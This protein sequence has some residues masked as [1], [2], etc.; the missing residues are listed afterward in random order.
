MSSW[1]FKN[2][3]R[4]IATAACVMASATAM[5]QD[6]KLTI[7]L[8][9]FSIGQGLSFIAQE[10]GFFKRERLDV[11]LLDARSGA[12]A[13]QAALS[14][15]VE[16]ATG[17]LD[18]TLNATAQ[19]K[20]VYVPLRLYSGLPGYLVV[21]KKLAAAAKLPANASVMDRLKALKGAT[22][23]SPS[24][25]STFTVMVKQAAEVAGVNVTVTYVANDGMVAALATGHVD[26]I[27]VSSPF[28]ERAV[29]QGAGVLWVDGP[30]GEFPGTEA[31]DFVVPLSVP[32][33]YYAANREVVERVIRAYLAASNFV[34]TNPAGAAKAI[35]GRFA[36]LDDALFN[37]V[38]D[39]NYQAFLTP[40]P[41][42]AAVKRTQ[43]NATGA[44]AVQVK[45]L[46]PD[47]MLLADVVKAAQASL[48]R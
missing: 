37:L 47:S 43:N 26:G 14:G 9:S 29:A 10:G 18:S 17:S 42:A 13:I 40:V 38:W 12:G 41:T 1:I 44:F 30:R 33:P 48:P 36:N 34:K 11:T 2:M 19:G 3:P 45:A 24:Q 28:A 27:I 4:W 25:S 21:T 39:R 7:A 31:D 16:L 46:N 22:I 20:M 15:S 6:T 32:A 8:S 23:A 5:A 35:R